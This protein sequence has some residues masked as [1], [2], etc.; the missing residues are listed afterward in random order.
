ML[1]FYGAIHA[2]EKESVEKI[3]TYQNEL[4]KTELNL[5]ETQ[6][7][8]VAEINTRYAEKILEIRGRPGGM[9]SKVGDFKETQK[10]KSAELEAVLTKEQFEKYEDELLPKMRKQMRSKMQ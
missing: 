7:Q 5:T 9:F 3:T 8:S 10:A 6:E 2:Q 4:M 1:V